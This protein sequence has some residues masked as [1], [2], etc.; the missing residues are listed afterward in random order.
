MIRR[1]EFAAA[2]LTAT[3]LAAMEAVGLAYER[4]PEPGDSLESLVDKCARA[5]SRLSAA[6]GR[7]RD[8]AARSWPWRKE[9]STI[10]RRSSHA[11]IA[12]L[13]VRRLPRSSPDKGWRLTWCAAPVP[14][15]VHVAPAAVSGMVRTIR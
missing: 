2:G 7:L 13:C 8:V 4:K 14:K 1:R 11:T 9:A 12:L 6:S 3:A 15:P 5:C 10:S